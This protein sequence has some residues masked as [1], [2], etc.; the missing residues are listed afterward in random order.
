MGGVSSGAPVISLN[1]NNPA[2]ITVG[3]TYGD[4]GAI[5]TGPTDADKNLGL[6]ASLDGGATTMPEQIII[7]TSVAGTHTILF[8]ATNQAGN[9]GYATRIVNVS[10]EGG[11]ASGGNVLSPLS[12][13]VDAVSTTTTVSADSI[14]SPQAD[15]ATVS[16]VADATTTTAAATTP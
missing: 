1:G 5:I 8:S 3:N 12:I 10:A 11:S 9:T 15:S 13:A 16:D 6:Q 7:D 14:N 4:L 2:T